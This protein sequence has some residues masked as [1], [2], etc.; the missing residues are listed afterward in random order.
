MFRGARVERFKKCLL[1]SC[2][3][4]R[5]RR[6]P[7]FRA[8]VRNPTEMFGNTTSICGG[9]YG[10]HI[11]GVGGGELGDETL[12]TVAFECC[13]SPCYDVCSL[14]S[15][16]PTVVG[17]YML[18]HVLAQH[19][20]TLLLKGIVAIVAAVFCGTGAAYWFYRLKRVAKVWSEE[21]AR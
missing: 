3:R 11:G 19:M 4:A 15:A 10:C 5:V 13:G 21:S 14:S 20:V 7:R 8:T 12:F 9:E 16:M 6:R 2:E 18:L 17:W 1:F